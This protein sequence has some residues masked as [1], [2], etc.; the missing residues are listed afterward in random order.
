MAVPGAIAPEGRNPRNHLFLHSSWDVAC[1]WQFDLI[2]RYTENLPTFGIDNYFEMDARLAWHPTETLEL[3]L[4]GR[5]LLD[6]AHPEFGS[7][8]FTGLFATE[9]RREVFGMVTW[10]Y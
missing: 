5:N 6:R 4:V 9:V 10:R 8:T 3:A 2:G 7:D 1:D